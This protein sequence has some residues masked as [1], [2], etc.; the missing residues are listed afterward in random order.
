[1]PKQPPRARRQLSCERDFQK[2]Y[3]TL[4]FVSLIHYM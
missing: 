4:Y 1:M 2:K 3:L